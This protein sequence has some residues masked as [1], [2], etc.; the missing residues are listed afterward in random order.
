MARTDRVLDVLDALRA[1]ESTSVSELAAEVGVSRRTLLRYLAILRDR[2]WPIEGE[3]GPGGGVRLDG[4]RGLSA[5]HLGV[6]EAV[7]LWLAARLS[8][9]QSPMPW[10]SAA[11]SALD[12]VL[13]SLPEDRRRRLRRF[14]RRVTVG[15]PATEQ[16]RA[17]LGKPSDSLI[18][19]LEQAFAADRCVSFVYTDRHARRSRRQVEPHGLMVEAPAWYLLARDLANGEARLF[20]MDRIR[21]PQLEETP[22]KPDSD[23]L[24]QEIF[25]SWRSTRNISKRGPPA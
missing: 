7:A 2:G 25:E 12:K 19:I 15:R 5:V 14:V 20:R 10:T 16:V 21:S 8:E 23:A 22:F 18:P 9:T 3:S 17:S 1:H 4:G 24:Q 13:A 6:A 11:R